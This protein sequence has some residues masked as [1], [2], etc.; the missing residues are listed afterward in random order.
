MSKI[1]QTKPAPTYDLLLKQFRSALTII[2]SQ[3]RQI[4]IMHQKYFTRQDME[5]LHEE[6]QSEREANQELTNL[7][8]ECEDKL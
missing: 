6:L 4:E 3:E 2:D 5:Y 7:L 1:T 8:Q